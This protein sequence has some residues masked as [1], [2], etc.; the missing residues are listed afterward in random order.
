MYE[1]NNLQKKI[2]LWIE[3]IVLTCLTEVFAV[4]RC[5]AVWIDSYQ[6]FGANRL[7]QNIGTKY[8]STLHLRRVNISFM[9]CQKPKFMQA[10]L[11][12]HVK[13]VAT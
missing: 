13:Y 4:L 11:S 9:L 5:C 10:E 8:Q 2:S 3:G 7:S 1:V 6:H 12:H